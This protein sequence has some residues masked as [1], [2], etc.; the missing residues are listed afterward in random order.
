M[1]VVKR[2]EQVP[3]GNGDLP[4]VKVKIKECGEF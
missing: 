2:I 1:E 3:T 4:K